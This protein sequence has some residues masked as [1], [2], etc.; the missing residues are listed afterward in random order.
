MQLIPLHSL[1]VSETHNVRKTNRTHNVDELTASIVAHGLLENLLVVSST[2]RLSS[3]S[4]QTPAT[5]AST[6]NGICSAKL[7]SPRYSAEPVRR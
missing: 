4:T 2:E 6:R 1:T 5:G 7:A 3:R